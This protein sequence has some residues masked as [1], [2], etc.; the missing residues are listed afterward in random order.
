MNITM[1]NVYLGDCFRIDNDSS[2]L[3]VDF[4][5]HR[6]SSLPYPLTRKNICEAV[7]DDLRQFKRLDMLVTHF[8]E[9]HIYGLIYMMK[10]YRHSLEF[11]TLYI[12]DIFSNT[13]STKAIPLILL[14]E[15]LSG[16][17]LG[18]A[19][20]NLCQFCK[21]ICRS[22]DHICFIKRGVQFCRNQYTALWPEIDSLEK[23]YD[24]LIKELS[25]DQKEFYRELRR[26]AAGITSIVRSLTGG[27]NEG[28]REMREQH[29]EQLSNLE[30]QLKDLYETIDLTEDERKMIQANN[31]ENWASIVFH[32]AVD[33]EQNILFTGD[34]E[35]R[36]MKKIISAKDIPLYQKYWCI[37]LPHHGTSTYYVDFY[38]YNPAV[39][40]V[41]SGKCPGVNKISTRYLTST[42]HRSV[43]RPYMYCSNCN[44]CE[45]WEPGK[46]CEC[47]PNRT[48]IYSKISKQV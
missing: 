41:P 15:L 36:F 40:M 32:N 44:W 2:H 13:I 26:I 4:G 38:Q 31:I 20:C 21:A 34:L 35:K 11:H 1:Y 28:Y 46:K 7:L 42:A 25:L 37:K 30:S 14:E 48:I 6:S 8:H 9:D 17:Y 45:A 47:S 33:C 16:Y 27:G 19:E 24:S 23:K 3:V 39:F 12:P 43:K 18:N 10:S 22:V 5:I 29:Q